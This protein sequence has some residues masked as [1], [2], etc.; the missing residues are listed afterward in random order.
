MLFEKKIVEIFSILIERHVRKTD[1]PVAMINGKMFVFKTFEDEKKLWV[2]ME[3]K[4][5]INNWIILIK[6]Y[7][8]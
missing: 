8:N 2:S 1:A 4:E 3:R 6:N 5:I 7:L